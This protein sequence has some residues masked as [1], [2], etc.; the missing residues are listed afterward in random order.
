MVYLLECSCGKQYVERTK[1]ALHV[2]VGEHLANISK[3][4][5]KHNLSRHFAFKHNKD[6]TQLKVVDIEVGI[7]HWRG[8][9]MVRHISR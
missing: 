4:F 8:M 7:P 5:P 1:R 9:N 3:R 2:R 6:P